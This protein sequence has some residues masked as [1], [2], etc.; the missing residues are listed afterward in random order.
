MNTHMDFK[1]SVDSVSNKAVS[2]QSADQPL[3]GDRLSQEEQPDYD[4]RRVLVAY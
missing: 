3:T 4:N 2:L 1:A